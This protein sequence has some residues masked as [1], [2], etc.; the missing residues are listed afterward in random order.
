MIR[1]QHRTTVL[2]VTTGCS[3][4]YGSNTSTPIIETELV[5]YVAGTAIVTPLD[6]RSGAVVLALDV[7][8]SAQGRIAV[9]SAGNSSVMLIGLAQKDS[10]QLTSQPT[11]LAFFNESTF[12][13][14]RNP[15]QV[16]EISSLG[17]VTKVLLLTADSVASTGHELFHR[18]TDTDLACASCH[19]EAGDD[20]HV[21]PLSDGLRKTPSLRGG[22]SGTKPFHWRG[23]L[24]DMN[25]LM[26]DVMGRRMQ[27]LNQSPERALAV[28]SWLDAQPA[29][30]VAPVDLAAAARGKAIFESAQTQCSS[31]H[32]G[33]QGTN[34]ATVDVGTGLP[35]QVPRL[36]ELARR[37]PWFHD[38]RVGTWDARYE[39]MAGGVKHGKTSGL[40]SNERSDLNVYLKSR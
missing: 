29:V 39:P 11:S 33:T 40:S 2:P 8:V 28:E 18:A 16:I 35:L 7:A 30:P 1:Q 3:S 14:T 12:V 31:C 32:S 36:T 20:G 5:N 24:S 22:I 21:W 13:F 25:S 23:D 4:Y 6:D 34:N 19:P 27:G 26:A 38:G 15:A 37:A 9:A 10:I 17:K